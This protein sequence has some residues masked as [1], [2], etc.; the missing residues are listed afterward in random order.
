MDILQQKSIKGKAI[1]TIF[2]GLTVT[3]LPTVERDEITHITVGDKNYRVQLRKVKAPRFDEDANWSMYE[4]S[5][6]DDLSNSLI[7]MYLFD[8]TEIIT[9]KREN[10][11]QKIIVGL[12]YIDNYEEAL[13]SIDEVRRSLLTALVDRKVTKYMQSI[14]AVIKKLE[15]DKYIFVFQYKYLSFLQNNKFSIL[16]EV[17]SVNIGNEMSVTI[18]IGLGVN[19]ENY[20]SS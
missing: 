11:E 4:N 12:L 6:S 13:E 18:S 17:R 1:N 8:E 5:D 19:A 16:D 9:L 2:P 3:S 7:A 14:D 10:K 20:I 15:K